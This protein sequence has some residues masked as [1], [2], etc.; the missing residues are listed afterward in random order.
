MRGR[1]DDDHGPST[2]HGSSPGTR[3]QKPAWV[4]DYASPWN[5]GT[6]ATAG[7]L[8]LIRPQATSTEGPLR[9]QKLELLRKEDGYAKPA[10]RFSDNAL[11]FPRPATTA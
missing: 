7:G 1:R 8:V 5:G 11:R 2:P 9:S 4:Q 3:L 10:S 6:L